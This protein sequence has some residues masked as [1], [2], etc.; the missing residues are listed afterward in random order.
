MKTARKTSLFPTGEQKK[1]AWLV[2]PGGASTQLVQNLQHLVDI[3]YTT[4]VHV[5]N[6]SLFTNSI[7]P[8]SSAR[9]G[10]IFQMPCATG[11]PALVDDFHFAINIEIAC[12]DSL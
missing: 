2:S 7:L 6:E 9:G 4:C 3:Q 5:S 1:T 8:V 11:V 12:A 10:C